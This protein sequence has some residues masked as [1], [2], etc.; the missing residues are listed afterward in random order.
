MA[1]YRSLF[2]GSSGN[3]SLVSENNEH[4]LIDLGKNCKQVCIALQQAGVLPRELS[5]I[6]ITHEHSDHIG[7]LRVFLKKYKI[8]VYGMSTTLDYLVEMGHIPADVD[9]VAIDGVKEQIGRFEV[10]AFATSHDSISCCGFKLRTA[11]GAA[12]SIATD[13][14]EVCEQV[15]SNLTGASLVVLE[16]NYDKTML[17]LGNYPYHL[18]VRI[19]SNRG[20]LSNDDT[21][22]TISRLIKEGCTQFAL[23]HL[24]SENNLPCIALDTVKEK[25]TKDGVCTMQDIAD[26]KILLKANK[27]Y[28]VS[29]PIEFL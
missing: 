23:C 29:D 4:L 25:I 5:G 8:T 15:Y 6:L 13:L 2:S 18:K 14:G 20:H 19:K 3:C 28:S 17:T 22:V 10:E 16:S 26:G 12:L 11:D 9:V 27:R 1:I 24:S 7:A 21:A